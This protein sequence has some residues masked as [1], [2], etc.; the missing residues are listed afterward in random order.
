MAYSFAALGACYML[1]AK[2]GI[3]ML[4]LGIIN[5]PIYAIEVNFIVSKKFENIVG[6]LGPVECNFVF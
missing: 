5:V 4:C 3:P 1:H 2:P 6:E